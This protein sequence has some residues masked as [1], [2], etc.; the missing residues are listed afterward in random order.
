MCPSIGGSSRQVVLLLVTSA[1]SEDGCLDQSCQTFS[2]KGY[3]VGIL[4]V[5][6]AVSVSAAQQ[7]RCSAGAA[8]A[9]IDVNGHG[10]V[11]IKLYLQNTSRP[12]RAQEPWADPCLH[13]LFIKGLI[14]W[15][16]LLLLCLP[17]LLG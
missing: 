6:H 14:K 7:G 11:P 9:D 1:G 15:D 12:D 3:T 5:G 13:C 10:R 16:I 8:K 2:I 4:S 17:Y